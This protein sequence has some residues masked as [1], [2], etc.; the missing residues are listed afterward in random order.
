[1][2]ADELRAIG[3]RVQGGVIDS[4]NQAQIDR[5]LLYSALEWMIERNIRWERNTHRDPMYTPDGGWTWFS[6]RDKAINALF[7]EQSQ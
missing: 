7:K 6:T 5:A 2:T 1:M 3:E 4:G